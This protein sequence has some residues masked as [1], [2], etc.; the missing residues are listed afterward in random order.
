MV[1]FKAL[2]KALF[3]IGFLALGASEAFAQKVT[4]RVASFL[5][6]RSM[7]V[8]GALLPWMEGVTKEVG[9]EVEFKGYW[10]GSLGRNPEKY[11]DLVKDGVADVAMML[12]G[13]T[14]GRFPGFAISELPLLSKSGAEIG[15]AHW[16]MFEAGYFKGFE[17]VKVIGVFGTEPFRIH[18]RNELKS[19]DDIKG[20]K[21]RAAGPIMSSSLSHLGAVPVG[22]PLNEATE[23]LSRGVVD[24]VLIGYSGIG[25]YKMDS[26]ARYHYEP[27][28]GSSVAVVAMNKKTW[29]SLSPRVKAAMEKYGGLEM[30]KVGGRLIDSEGAMFLSKMKKSG[31][32]HF[33]EAN[34][35][36]QEKGMEAFR[37]VHDEWIKSNEDGQAKYDAYLKF[38]SEIRAGK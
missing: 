1:T 33:I 32:H 35:E 31:D 13:Y 19:G 17:E 25:I 14:P 6:D 38:L 9:D 30:A 23:A 11:F 18:T 36:I 7:V 3:L 34:K 2:Y 10:G 5:P 37:P 29:N 28:L 20:L 24:G 22:I 27:T 16:K 15:Q 8:R 26:I 4:L 12:P 21:V